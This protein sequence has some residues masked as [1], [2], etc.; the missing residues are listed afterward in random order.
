MPRQEA[1]SSRLISV[2]SSTSNA[3]EVEPLPERLDVE[4]FLDVMK[5]GVPVFDVRTPAEFERGHVPGARNLPLFTN[6]ERALVGT[7]YKHE[8]RHAALLEGLDYVGPRMRDLIEEVRRHVGD[9][10]QPVLVHCWRGGMRS[11]SVAWLLRTYGYDVATLEG[12]YKAFRRWVLNQLE[13]PPEL[14]V[15]GGSTGAGK[16]EILLELQKLGEPV[17]DLE[18]LANHRG[19]AFGGLLMPA[20]PP[21]EHFENRLGLKISLARERGRPVWV[22]DESKAIGHDHLPKAVMEKIRSSAVIYV[23]LPLELRVRRLVSVYG[24]APVD[25][26]RESFERISSRLGGERT[27]EALQALDDG[28]LAGAV[29]IALFYYDRAYAQGLSRREAP[30]I[31]RLESDDDSFTVAQTVLEFAKQ[32]DKLEEPQ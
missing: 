21:Q 3:G 22:E 17:I 1:F 11:G 12:G 32:I 15:L 28:D 27:R 26:L 14:R 25:A 4:T 9:A 18:D 10:P 29:R 19:S 23:E 16:T 20:Q 2:E 6:E 5:Q 30:S 8:G 31:H 7:T 13:A 24:D